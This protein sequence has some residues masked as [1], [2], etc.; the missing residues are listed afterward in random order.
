MFILN[1][2]LNNFHCED[3]QQLTVPYTKLQL[4]T[5]NTSIFHIQES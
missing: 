2:I 1:R 4:T 5:S 3:I